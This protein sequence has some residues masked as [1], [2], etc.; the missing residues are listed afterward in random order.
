MH[1]SEHLGQAAGVEFLDLLKEGLQ[2]S[3]SLGVEAVDIHTHGIYVID[4]LGVG[5]FNLD[6]RIEGE[7]VDE[8]AQ[9]RLGVLAQQVEHAVA[10]IFGSQRMRGH[11]SAVGILVEVIGRAHIRIEISEVYAMA[12]DRR[13]RRGRHSYRE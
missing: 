13:G 1:P 5:A 4:F 11:P 7:G 8:L 10:G 3:S 9:L 2:R 6:I 12:A